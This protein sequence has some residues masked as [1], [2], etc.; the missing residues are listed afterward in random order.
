M[1]HTTITDCFL[2][3][4]VNTPEFIIR[5]YNSGTCQIAPSKLSQDCVAIMKT[6]DNVHQKLS[7]CITEYHSQLL[8]TK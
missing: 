3:A 5:R 4:N 1:Y 2:L 8:A 7:E 6:Q